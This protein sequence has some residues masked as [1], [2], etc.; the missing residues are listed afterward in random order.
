MPNFDDAT[1]T[2]PPADKAGY[3][4]V[5]GIDLYYAVYGSG[6]PLIMLHGGFSLGDAFASVMPVIGAGR[7]V[8]T[9]DLQG[10]G[11]TA[12]IDRPLLWDAMADD[13]G[14]LIGF[15]GLNKPDLLGYS[16]GGGVALNLAIRHPELVEKLVLVSTPR[17]RA[18]WYPAMQ[19]A[20]A[21]NNAASAEMLKGTAMYRAYAAV[22]PR[23]EDFGRLADKLGILLG[24][25]YDWSEAV[26]KLRLPVLLAYGDADGIPP[27]NAA[28]FFAL[29]G[30]GQRDGNWDGSGM[31]ASRLAILP[32]ATHY[33]ILAAPGLDRMVADFLDA[34]R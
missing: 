13:V 6:R 25:P 27:V 34:A 21:H 26:A 24:T 10:H 16:L 5:N 30:G 8:I 28:A 33:N 11:H 32:A 22:A 2:M 31:S 19:A 9:V 20:M 23:P 3:A 18:D 7:E 15:L 29:L 4:R 12:D 17:R 14:E 1:A